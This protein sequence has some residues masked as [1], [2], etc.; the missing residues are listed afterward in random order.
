MD[1]PDA[2]PSTETLLATDPSKEASRDSTNATD[3]WYWLRG[4][5]SQAQPAVPPDD[6]NTPLDAK[7]NNEYVG[8][9]ACSQ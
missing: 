6:H 3:V 5:D 2:A 8:C 9:K 7:V 1:M 4:L